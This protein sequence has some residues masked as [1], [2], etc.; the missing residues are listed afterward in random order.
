MSYSCKYLL[1][2]L[3]FPTGNTLPESSFLV[4]RQ[5]CPWPHLPNE[6]LSREWW[7]QTNVNQMLCVSVYLKLLLLLLLLIFLLFI[8]CTIN[9]DHYFPSP[10]S[11]RQCYS[12]QRFWI[13]QRLESLGRILAIWQIFQI[14]LG[15]SR[16]WPQM[17][18]ITCSCF[19]WV[20]CV[21]TQTILQ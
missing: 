15:Q 7:V 10:A 5:H 21:L 2:G 19:S 14:V 6:N 18:K 20:W 8:H 9:K 4:R 16:S 11:E 12:L 13:S 1:W 3:T 17:Q